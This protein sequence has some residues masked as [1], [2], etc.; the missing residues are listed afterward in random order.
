MKTIIFTDLDGTL[1]D[2]KTYSYQKAK[3]A[4]KVVKKT[5]TPLIVCT[6]KTGA[7]IKEFRKQ[8]KNKDPFI[9][10]DGGAIFIPKRYFDF[11]FKYNKEKQGYFVIELGT[12]YERL[13][14]VLDK[15][16][17]KYN[18]VG[19]GDLTAKELAKDS[20]L[21]LKKA[22][23][24]LKREYDE[25]FKI[26]NKK[27]QSKVIDEIKKN[28]LNYTKGGR[29]WHLIGKNDKGKA[30]KILYKLFKRKFKK[31]KTIGIGDSANDFPMLDS[32]DKGFLVQRPNNL[33]TSKRY[34]KAKGIGPIGW[35][36]VIQNEF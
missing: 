24:A 27:G 8:I 3:P 17:K 25:P 2:H 5:K 33:Y 13:R 7:E 10:E 32:V 36:K 22:K 30:V 21:S 4:L 19:F 16:K 26:L 14:K 12:D 34:L 18:V 9:S 28:K 23:L 29:Y 35:D 11:K 6:S 15:I 1:L 20:G 31:I